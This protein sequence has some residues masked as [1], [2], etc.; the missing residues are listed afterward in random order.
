[1]LK[2]P[3]SK[4]ELMEILLVEKKKWL[5]KSFEEYLELLPTPDESHYY[6]LELDGITICV[7]VQLLEG[8]GAHRHAYVQP[9]MLVTDGT[10]SGGFFGFFAAVNSV[11]EG[12]VVF[13]DGKVWD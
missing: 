2:L 9:F 6:T 12:W 5:E 3:L 8:G 13:R 7:E 11:A 10:T 4:D 1:M